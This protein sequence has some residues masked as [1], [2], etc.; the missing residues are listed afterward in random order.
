M[1]AQKLQWDIGN[2]DNKDICE[3]RKSWI[4][5][6]SEI[7]GSLVY[8]LTVELA[9]DI[10]QYLKLEP[11]DDPNIQTYISELIKLAIWLTESPSRGIWKGRRITTG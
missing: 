10:C 8:D 9:G 1:S 6:L 5:R 11:S 4:W 2:F 7:F 3:V